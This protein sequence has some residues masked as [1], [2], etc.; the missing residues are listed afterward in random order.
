MIVQCKECKTKY[1]FDES[2]ID[3]EG[4]WVRCS[5]CKALFF[6]EKPAAE[7]MLSPLLETG[8]E[9][10]RIRLWEK[11]QVPI[12]DDLEPDFA[13]TSRL[14]TDRKEE[15]PDSLETEHPEQIREQER[16]PGPQIKAAGK[17]LGE[18]DRDHLKVDKADDLKIQHEEEDGPKIEEKPA[19]SKG[20]QWLYLLVVL[21]LFGVYLWFFSE[22][23]RQ[24][25]DFTSSVATTLIEKIHGAPLKKEDVGPAQVDLTDIRQRLVANGSLGIIRVVEGTAVNQ[26]VHPMTRIRIRGEIVGDGGVLLGERESYCG[27]L[28]TVDELATMTE[29]QL[30]KELSNPQG[31][32]VSNDRIAPKGQIPF[33]IVFAREP[34]GVVKTFVVPSGAERL[35]P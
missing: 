13:Q 34:V 14:F 19:R 27:N 21:L 9:D 24:S 15:K 30:Q 26:A 18:F 12:K 3:E 22:I 7:K 28:L 35:L 4:A 31:S 10:T 5:R 11:T 33:M 1:R 29:D 6:L 25:A 17:D 16:D 8:T 20:K 23:G 2:L 32:D